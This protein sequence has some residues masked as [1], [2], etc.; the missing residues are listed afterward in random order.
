MFAAARERVDVIFGISWV[1]GEMPLSRFGGGG[2]VFLT[3][4]VTEG[5]RPLTPRPPLPQGERGSYASRGGV[6]LGGDGICGA[7]EPM[8]SPYRFDMGGRINCACRAWYRLEGGTSVAPTDSTWAGSVIYAGRGKARRPSH[9]LSP[10]RKRH[11]S[12]LRFR[13]AVAA[14][15]ML[16]RFDGRRRWRASP[17]IRR[18]CIGS[19]RNT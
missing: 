1:R 18:R 13:S 6:A 16:L 5:G 11:R 9:A 4:E 8:A 12:A 15:W 7:G 19:L 2:M 3:T 10:R 14:V 17:C